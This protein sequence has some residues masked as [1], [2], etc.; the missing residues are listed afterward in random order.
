MSDASLETRAKILSVARTRFAT[1]GYYGTSVDSIVKGTGLSKGAIYWHFSGKW[2]IYK[3]VL[4]AEAEQIKDLILPRADTNLDV[5]AFLSDRGKL[6][7]DEMAADTECRLLWI[8][9]GL[10]SIGDNP[11]IKGLVFSL[12]NSLISDVVAILG[13]EWKNEDESLSLRSIIAMFEFIMHGIMLNIGVS[14]S[15]EEAKQSWEF[16]VRRMFGGKS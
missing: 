12:S 2:D 6:L 9:I 8:R 4:N 15:A 13:E 3:S 1:K 11:E 5:P 10:E 14:V 16:L 7:I